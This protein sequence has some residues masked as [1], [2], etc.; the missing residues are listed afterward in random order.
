M[1]LRTQWW[2]CQARFVTGDR[3]AAVG[4]ALVWIAASLTAMLM[5]LR[6]GHRSVLILGTLGLWY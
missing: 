4:L 5:G 2:K 1:A 3:V 6:R